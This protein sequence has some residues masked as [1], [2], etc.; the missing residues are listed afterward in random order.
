MQFR[1]APQFAHDVVSA[2]IELGYPPTS[3]LNG[4]THTGFTIAQTQNE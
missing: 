1:Y 2:A 4:E 3:D